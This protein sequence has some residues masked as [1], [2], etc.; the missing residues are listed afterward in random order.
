MRDEETFFSSLLIKSII[1]ATADTFA[2]K[3]QKH[4]AQCLTT[5][6]YSSFYHMALLLFTIVRLCYIFLLFLISRN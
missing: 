2:V 1:D 3:Q 4:F 5:T 6:Q